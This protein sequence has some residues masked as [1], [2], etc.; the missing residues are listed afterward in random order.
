A[1]AMPNRARSTPPPGP[2]GRS[3]RY[4]REKRD[5]RS[6]CCIRP[7][8]IVE[9]ELERRR[10]HLDREAGRARR[11]ISCIRNHAGVDEMLVQMVDIFR[12]AAF[13]RARK[14]EI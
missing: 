1:P 2:E 13:G 6:S 14:A 3:P 11:L 10:L 4:W 8:W 12:D 7:F 5:D 9:I